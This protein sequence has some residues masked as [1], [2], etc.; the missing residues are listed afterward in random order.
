MTRTVPTEHAEKR[1][2]MRDCLLLDI[3]VFLLIYVTDTTLFMRSPFSL[4]QTFRTLLPLVGVC[5]LL[6]YFF[7]TKKSIEGKLIL[8]FTV[9]CAAFFLSLIFFGGVMNAVFMYLLKILFC[10]FLA[11]AVPFERFCDSFLRVMRIIALVALVS[12]IIYQITPSFADLFPKYVSTG[13]KEGA[14]LEWSNLL[15]TQLP[16]SGDTAWSTRNFGPFKNPLDRT[17]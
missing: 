6:F 14:T 16:L 7:L 11:M 9:Y 15:F 10:V 1:R 17:T 5:L 3:V 4:L 2:Y 12:Y 8:Y 13:S